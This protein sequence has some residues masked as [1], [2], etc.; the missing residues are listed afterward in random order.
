MP[1]RVRVESRIRFSPRLSPLSLAEK[2][3]G[4]RTLVRGQLVASVSGV[5]LG[6]PAVGTEFP[7]RGEN[8]FGG[9]GSTQFALHFARDLV[10]GE[11]TIR[12][13]KH[14]KN[15]SLKRRGLRVGLEVCASY[16]VRGNKLSECRKNR[17]QDIRIRLSVPRFRRPAFRA[18]EAPSEHLVNRRSVFGLV[19]VK[20]G[21][22]TSCKLQ[23]AL[24][25][26]DFVQPPTVTLELFECWSPVNVARPFRVFQS[27]LVF[28][29]AKIATQRKVPKVE[30]CTLVNPLVELVDSIGESLS[31]C[32]NPTECAIT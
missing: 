31:A 11:R 29:F 3:R 24:K 2:F 10:S 22:P 9:L 16:A 1:H 28:G 13:E 17:A 6:K 14:V 20:N 30:P 26:E 21:Q 25:T 5:K 23:I 15:A 7:D 27:S 4:K 19:S 32:R 18:I 12:V 8:R